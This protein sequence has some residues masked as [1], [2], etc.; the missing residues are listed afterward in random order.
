MT[1]K[2]IKNGEASYISPTGIVTKKDKREADLLSNDM[3]KGMVSLEDQ[4]IKD[5]WLTDT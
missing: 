5:G 3:G 2:V 4:F 1:I